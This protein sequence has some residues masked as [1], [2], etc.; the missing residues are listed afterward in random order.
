MTTIEFDKRVL[1]GLVRKAIREAVAITR[2]E[3]RCVED[4]FI[5]FAM[6]RGLLRGERPPLNSSHRWE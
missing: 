3:E 1:R 2:A 4:A 6:Q 5:R